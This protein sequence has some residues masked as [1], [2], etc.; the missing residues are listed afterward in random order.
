MQQNTFLIQK[1]GMS[2][3]P[4]SSDNV[5]QVL[6][7]RNLDFVRA[8]MLNQQTITVSEHQAW[9]ERV[10][11]DD[12]ELH[13]VIEYKDAGV[14]AAN[15]KL[16]GKY[17]ESGLYLSDE[18]IRGSAY[19]FL[20]S[21]LLLEFAFDTLKLTEVRATVLL[22]NAAA[23]RFNTQQGY[24]IVEENADHIMMRITPKLFNPKKQ[25]LY[26]FFDR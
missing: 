24:E 11:G 22:H 25:K 19:A 16:K 9:F 21:L 26:R 15:L 12:S 14:G 23:L 13:F 4:L 3:V 10:C 20:P 7:W 5:G 1:F 2:L 18:A 17:A 8:N 6:D